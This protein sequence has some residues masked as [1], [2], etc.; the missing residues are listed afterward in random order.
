MA[1]MA[2]EKHSCAEMARTPVARRTTRGGPQCPRE[3]PAELLQAILFD[4][5]KPY[6][7]LGE[8]EL[9]LAVTGH[10][11]DFAMA[12]SFPTVLLLDEAQHLSLAVL[13]ELRLL[14]NLE[15]R[16]GAAVP[17]ARAAARSAG[18]V[19]AATPLT[20]RSRNV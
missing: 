5:A 20:N 9:R 3:R 8:Q 15:T 16:R 6:Q 1:R 4:L 19:S 14:G 2:L 11:L 13:E 7:G 17:A 18:L 10:L 12:G